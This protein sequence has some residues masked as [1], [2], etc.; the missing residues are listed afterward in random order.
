MGAP[1]MGFGGPPPD[2]K[3][4]LRDKLTPE[5]HDAVIEKVFRRSWFM[6]GMLTDIPDAG[7]YFVYDV[8]TFKT[9]VLVVRGADGA[10]RAFHN[11]CR[12]RGKKVV[13][14]QC[15]WAE[16][17]AH[18]FT[19]W[20][21]GWSY[22]LDGG[23]KF[24]PAERTFVGLNK[25]EMGLKPIVTE[26][27]AGLILCYFGE[28]EPPDL[29]TY[30]AGLHDGFDNY[31]TDMER[32]ATFAGDMR[33]N[34]AFGIDSFSEGYHVLA[35]HRNTQPEVPGAQGRS[36]PPPPPMIDIFGP[37]IC[38]GG[39]ASPDY[40]SAPVER[41]LFRLGRKLTPAPETDHSMLPPAVNRGRHPSWFFDVVTMFPNFSILNGPHWV[42]TVM[43]WPIDVDHCRVITTHYA[44]KA[45]HAGD[46][47]A[48]AYMRGVL[49]SVTREDFGAME[50]VQEGVESG[51]LDHMHLS[52]LEMALT[53]RYALIEELIKS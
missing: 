25:S 17:K 6:L 2:G 36:A 30:L 12:H 4:S 27:W 37:H 5:Y 33:N 9:S 52:M 44:R 39:A 23:L 16:G 50:E 15:A 40:Q 35:L 8:P 43:V 28:G 22:N 10:V 42:S 47:L 38:V 41:A 20:L 7:S 18:G 21:H 46:R 13:Q 32:I 48:Q 14:T 1:P 24:V 26:V 34:W 29:K 19:C 11:V 49:V 45:R 53:K 3:V 31:Y 51:A